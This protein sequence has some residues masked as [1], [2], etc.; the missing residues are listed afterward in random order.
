VGGIHK[1]KSTSDHVTGTRVTATSLESGFE[2]ITAAGALDPDI[3]TSF[4]TSGDAI[5]LT[6]AAGKVNGA[7][8]IV[9]M[10]S[11]GGDAT[12]TPA[13][14]GDNTTITFDNTDS[15][16]GIFVNGSWWTIG[17]PTATEA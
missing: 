1:S 13:S 11:D 2:H 14:F 17:T 8:K 15:W 5:A 4:I 12:L 9:K 3:T 7:V 16:M 10:I 6:L